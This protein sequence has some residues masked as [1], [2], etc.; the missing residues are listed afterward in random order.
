MEV[1]DNNAPFWRPIQQQE[2]NKQGIILP[3]RQLAS[4]LL[5]QTPSHFH[6]IK[7]DTWE[8]MESGSPI[9]LRWQ[10]K[11]HTLTINDVQ[12]HRTARLI[13]KSHADLTSTR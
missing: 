9:R 8:S 13:I 5:N 12:H 10:A 7:H 11:L 4:I 3:P 6:K 1:R 2:L